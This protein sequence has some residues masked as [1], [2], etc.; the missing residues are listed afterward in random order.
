ME[1]LS[2]LTTGMAMSNY[3]GGS[4]THNDGPLH[5]CLLVDRVNVLIPLAEQIASDGVAKKFGLQNDAQVEALMEDGKDSGFDKETIALYRSTWN[6]LFH[7][8]MNRLT[9]DAGLR[10]LVE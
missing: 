5:D 1:G 3:R 4:C 10:R 6:G 8:A 9:S 7:R 2:P